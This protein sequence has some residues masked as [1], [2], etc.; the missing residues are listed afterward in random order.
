MASKESLKVSEKV[1]EFLNNIM[2][3]RIKL[4][5]VPLGSYSEAIELMQRYFKPREKEYLKMIKEES[6]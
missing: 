4:D 5:Q 6:Q 3:N 2:I 1:K